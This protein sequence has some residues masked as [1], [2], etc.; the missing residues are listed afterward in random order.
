MLACV[1]V[2]AQANSELTGIVT[3]QTG[4]VVPDAKIT[5][6]DPATGIQNPQSAGEPVYTTSPV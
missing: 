4:A 2:W 6:T 3:D 5:V 1:S